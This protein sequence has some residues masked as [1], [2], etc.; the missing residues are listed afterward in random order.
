MARKDLY[1]DLG[2]APDGHGRRDQEGVPQARAQAPPGRQSRQQRGRG[3][4]QGVSF[5][6]DVL[7]RPREAQA[8]RRVRRGRPAGRLRCRP[9]P[10]VPRRQSSRGSAPAAAA[11]SAATRASRT[12][13]ATSR[14][15]S[16]A[17]G[18]RSAARERR[19]RR[20]RSSTSICSMRCA[21]D[22]RRSPSRSRSPVLT[23]GGTG[24][25]RGHGLPGVRRAR[26]DQDGRRPMSF[27]RLPALQRRVGR[28]SPSRVPRCGAT[29][30]IDKLE[31][32][33]VKIPA[34]VDDGSRI[35]LAGKG[36]AGRGGAPPGDLYIV[37]RC[38][39]TRFSSA[40]ATISISISGHGRRGDARRRRSTC[41]PPTGTV[42]AQ[43]AA[44]QPERASCGCAARAC[45]R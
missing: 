38:A 2:V 39:R 1:G 15:R 26:P 28:A 35:R 37:V 33:N 25:A 40:A 23:C 32:L 9:R 14:R 22:R 34:G 41:R 4:L 7:A 44:R 27:G 10:R 17:T 13:S 11:A 42:Q 30:A 3:A 18:R 45:R 31:Q 36:G 19:R 16:A 43:G 20:R 6:H 12:S 29:V 8:L 5:A 21:A 24:R